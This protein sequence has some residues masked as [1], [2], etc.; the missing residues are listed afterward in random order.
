MLRCKRFMSEKAGARNDS[1]KDDKSVP[2]NSTPKGHDGLEIRSDTFIPSAR[3]IWSFVTC[4]NL[5]CA[6][7]V[8]QAA[9]D[10]K[11]IN[12]SEACKGD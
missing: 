12:P 5:Q 10:C 2:V 7:Q 9:I 6:C 4:S 8:Q 11:R 3:L 1:A